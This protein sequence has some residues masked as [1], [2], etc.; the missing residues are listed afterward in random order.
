MSPPCAGFFLARKWKSEMP[1]DDTPSGLGRVLSVLSVEFLGL[2]MLVGI[3]WGTLTSKVSGLES[4]VED[5][6]SITAQE[7]VQTK[8][9]TDDLSK[10]VNQINR[11]VDVLGTNQEHFKAQINRVDDRLEKIQDILEQQGNK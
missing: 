1:N 4:A 6:K 2:L 7:V 11:K 9:V 8:Q 3:S 10:E 5:Q